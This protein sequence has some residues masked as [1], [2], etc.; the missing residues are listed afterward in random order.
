MLTHPI[1]MGVGALNWSSHMIQLDF[2]FSGSSLGPKL[3]LSSLASEAKHCAV[4]AKH[5]VS[6][7]QTQRRRE[8]QTRTAC[9][10]GYACMRSV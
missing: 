8:R 6:G 3:F 1:M 10:F 2:V 4:I 9:I 5:A 7:V